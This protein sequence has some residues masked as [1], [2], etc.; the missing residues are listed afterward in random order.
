MDSARGQSQA[1]GALITY[2]FPGVL[3]ELRPHRVAKCAAGQGQGNQRRAGAQR[4]LLAL[5]PR[6]L[7]GEGHPRRHLDA[8]QRRK[9]EVIRPAVPAAA[10]R[11]A[12]PPIKS[13]EWTEQ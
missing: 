7:G 8:A 10:R 12:Q 11:R 5:H 9:G 1:A 3:P 4:D 13:G 6:P 2:A